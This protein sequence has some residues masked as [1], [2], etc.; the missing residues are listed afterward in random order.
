MIRF[1]RGEE[2]PV[3]AEIRAKQLAKLREIV[4]REGRDPRSNEIS[5]YGH[6]DIRNALYTAQGGKCCYCE[7]EIEPKR[8]DIDHFRPKAAADRSPGSDAKHGYWWLGCTWK[9]LLY[10]C[11]Q[12][13]EDF[14]K[15]QF[16]LEAGSTSLIAEEEAP[17]REMPLLIGPA[18]ESG[19]KH[20]K[21]ERELRGERGYW[22]P[23]PRNGSSKGYWTIR[24]CGLDRDGLMSMYR[25]H[26]ER[27]VIP[28]RDNIRRAIQD[29]D[30]RAVRGEFQ[31]TYRAL[32]NRD[33]RFIGLSYDALVFFTEEQ[34]APWGLSWPMPE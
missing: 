11:P 22:V 2:P 17:G 14:K 4:R 31:R 27:T 8:E 15:I 6:Q 26:V 1:D 12:C 28:Y 32:L 13:N 3:L 23:R 34:L 19:V 24:V 21:F 7:R 5:G 10:S 20:I 9:N 18:A 16:P 25:N 29:T 33:Q 30:P